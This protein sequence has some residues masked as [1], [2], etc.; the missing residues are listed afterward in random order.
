MPSKGNRASD[1]VSSGGNRCLSGRG[2]CPFDPVCPVAPTRGLGRMSHSVGILT[3]GPRPDSRFQASDHF[4]STLKAGAI[5][6]KPWDRCSVGL[7]VETLNPGHRPGTGTVDRA[8]DTGSPQPLNAWTA[9]RPG[10]PV[11]RPVHSASRKTPALGW[12]DIQEREPHRPW[13][14]H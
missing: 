11:G 9:G 2:V 4:L 1:Q 8:R 14:Q 12:G 6:H 10:G 3:P 5:S 13:P 7:A